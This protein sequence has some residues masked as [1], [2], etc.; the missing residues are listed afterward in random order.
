M[1]APD[2]E[3]L[4]TTFTDLARISSPSWREAGVIRYIM[5]RLQ[6]LRVPYEKHPCGE[7]FNLLAR[8]PGDSSKEAILFSC[9]TDTVGPC[10]KVTPI[11]K[12]NKITSDE[13]S[14]LGADNK[15]AIACF[16]EALHLIREKKI[17][18]GP[19]EFI[20]SCAEEVGLYGI[21]GFDISQLTATAAFVFDSSGKIGK[22]VVEAPFDMTMEL[23]MRGKAA[24]AGIEPERGIS[25]IR[26]LSEIIS[27]I[28]HG[29]IDAES[30]V[31]VGIISGGTAT[32]I[33]AEEAYAKLEAR[34]RSLQ[35]LKKIESEIRRISK[36]EARR[37]GAKASITKNLEYAGFSLNQEQRVVSI[38]KR[39]LER[40]GTAP[41][42]VS[43]GGGS[44][45]NILNRA[46]IPAV[47]LSIGMMNAHTKKE[48]ILITD[49]IKATRLVLSIIDCA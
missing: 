14:I 20:F 22:I 9:H 8:L 27:R 44:D 26:V 39:A 28:P 23:T 19:I 35:Q 3:Q 37:Y 30:T 45:T 17:P 1:H 43:T 47:N 25:A 38:A 12:G 31:N 40:I 34:S 15:A 7:S 6:K 33:V 49:L 5:K 4:I 24:H 41:Q 48:Y 46:G 18:H 29:R 21:K 32:N 11:I 16:L 2:Q 36:H 13:T 42:T 10:E